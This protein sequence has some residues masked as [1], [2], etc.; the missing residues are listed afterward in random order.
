ML[1]IIA[2]SVVKLECGVDWF[3]LI[4]CSEGVWGEVSCESVEIVRTAFLRCVV[5]SRNEMKYVLC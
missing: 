1:C 3:A 5:G 4:G 2:L